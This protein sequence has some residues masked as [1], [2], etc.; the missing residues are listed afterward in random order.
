MNQPDFPRIT[1]ENIRRTLLV[2][3]SLTDPELRLVAANQ[4]VFDVE[5]LAAKVGIDVRRYDGDAVVVWAC[6]SAGRPSASFASTVSIPCS[7][8][9]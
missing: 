4:L 5:A 2:F 6:V 9:L 8:R 1:L 7:C 3:D